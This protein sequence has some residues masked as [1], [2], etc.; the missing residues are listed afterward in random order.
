[1]R[2]GKVGPDWRRGREGVTRPTTGN[3]HTGF[4]CWWWL[5]GEAEATIFCFCCWV[6]TRSC[7]II[8]L[9]TDCEIPA[10]R[11]INTG[12][13]KSPT[14]IEWQTNIYIGLGFDWIFYFKEISI[15]LH[16][17]YFKT[18][19]TFIYY[20]NAC[21]L[22]LYNHIKFVWKTHF[23]VQT[24]SIKQRSAINS[25]PCAARQTSAQW[26]VTWMHHSTQSKSEVTRSQRQTDQ[27]IH[28]PIIWAQT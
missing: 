7:K 27:I 5:G 1:M 12:K 6:K 26:T 22:L 11:R 2:G 4:L 10:S 8:K 24:S 19:S 23:A 20:I 15:F 13:I 25:S 14:I 9:K 3:K 28:P 18:Y 21:H 16:N 17:T